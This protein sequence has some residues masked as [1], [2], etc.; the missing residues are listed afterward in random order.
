[1][2]HRQCDLGLEL[3]GMVSSLPSHCFSPEHI[4]HLGGNTYRHLM[5]VQ[6]GG[7][8]SNR[9]HDVRDVA[10]GEDF[11]P[12]P[13]QPRPLRLAAELRPQPVALQWGQ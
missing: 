4:A 3:G 2:D 9:L 8:S 10:V 6:L 1:M 12:H 5:T 7:S 13:S 11:Q